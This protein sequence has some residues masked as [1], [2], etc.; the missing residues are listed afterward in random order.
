MDVC[1]NSFWSFIS[2]LCFLKQSLVVLDEL[3]RGTSTYDGYAIAYAVLKHVAETVG[4]RTLFSTHYHMLT[5]EFEGRADLVSLCHMACQVLPDTQEIIFTYKLMPGLCPNS[6]GMNVAVSA[7]LPREVIRRAKEVSAEF[8]QTSAL[9]QREKLLALL[10][11]VRKVV[12]ASLHHDPAALR[13][14]RTTVSVPK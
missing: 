7:G 3:G 11:T 12:S 4:C 10:S 14:L 8:A 6:Y 9:A 2:F 5:R 13:Q 1:L